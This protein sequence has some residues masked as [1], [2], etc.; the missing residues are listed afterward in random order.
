[1]RRPRSRLADSALLSDGSFT[2]APALLQTFAREA[3]A[4]RA[5]DKA[6]SI[7]RH[8]LPFSLDTTA[9]TISG[10][11]ADD[12]GASGSD[13]L[14][15]EPE[16]AGTATDANGISKFSDARD[17]GAGPAAASAVQLD[18]SSSY[19][20]NNGAGAPVVAGASSALEKLE[21]SFHQDLN[22]GGLIGLAVMS[23]GT[24]EVSSAY[25]GPATFMGSSGILQLDQSASF[26]GTVAG[27]TG[28]DTLDL[29]DINFATIQSPTYSGTS[30]G[31]TLS[32][33]DGTHNAQIALLGNYL[34]STFVASSDGHGGTNVVDP[35]IGDEFVGP[36]PSWIN[37]KTAYG[38]KG[39]GI[40]DD[41]AAF[42]RA[43][44][45]LGAAGHGD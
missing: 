45:E 13:G 43:L 22:G 34:A 23:G 31:G 9:A 25:S 29:R 12:T 27:M 4:D 15:D 32:V 1:M 10:R 30:S 38:A 26:S 16:V 33:S 6:G 36:F 8:D 41:T 35:S 24:V 7:S 17:R 44:T 19:A 42:Q 3:L 28:Q 20:P 37:I 40:T 21:P 18:G 2:L 39:D 5:T 11:L 14:T